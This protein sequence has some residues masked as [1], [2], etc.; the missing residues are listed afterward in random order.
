MSW[1]TIRREH[2]FAGIVG[3]GNTAGSDITGLGG[4]RNVGELDVGWE[5]I[6]DLERHDG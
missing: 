5:A 6:S 2:T 1:R 3:N 4:V